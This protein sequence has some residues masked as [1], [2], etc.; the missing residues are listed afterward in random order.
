MI[1]KVLTI[2]AAGFQYDWFEGRREALIKGVKEIGADVIFLQE[3]TVFPERKYDQTLDIMKGCGLSHSAFCPYGNIK[4]YQSP[5]LGGI[6]ILSR[7]PF[8]FVQTRKLPFGTLDEY[9]ARSGLF[10]S[11]VIDGVEVLFA[12]TH[13][14]W[15]KEERD[16]RHEQMKVFL[17]AVKHYGHEKTVF[18]GD[19]NDDELG[20][21]LLREKFVEAFSEGPTYKERKI[22]Y[23]FC[24]KE[25]QV[26]KCEVVLNKEFVSDHS[27]VVGVFRV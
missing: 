23:L 18:G 24:S 4:E 9:G 3:T 17:E 26:V 13:L 5:K 6:G 20:E 16:L 14:S 25:V 19:F 21:M 1:I 8:S 27:G 11:V 12:T 10:A 15:R 22:D 7:W 2:N